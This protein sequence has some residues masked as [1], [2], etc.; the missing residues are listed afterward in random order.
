[1]TRDQ[2]EHAIRAACEVAGDTEVWVFGSQAILGEYP[3]AP[4]SLCASVEVDIQP[5]NHPEKVDE[6]DGSLGELSAFYES[7]GF[8]VHGV[9]L[10]AASLPCGWQS[11]VIP[12]MDEIRTQGKT[13]LCIE[14]HDLAASKLV[15]YR[16]KDRD[17]VRTLLGEGLIRG[18]TLRKRLAALDVDEQLRARLLRWLDVSLKELP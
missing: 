7:F 10:A 17:F 18:T 3:D 8:Y 5:K 15:A 2:L 12:V 13:G 16:E 1:M 14:A 9:S 4:R 11:R 6:V